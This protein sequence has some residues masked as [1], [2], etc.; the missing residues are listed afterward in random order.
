MLHQLFAQADYSYSYSYSTNSG[1]GG[2]AIPA[3]AWVFILAIIVLV[4]VG[5]WKMFAKAG[6]PGWA[7]IIPIYNVIVLLEIAAKPLWWIVL[8]FIPFVNIVAVIL[9]WIEVGRRFGKGPGFSVVLLWLLSPIGQLILG[10][11]SA[12]YHADPDAVASQGT[13]PSTPYPQASNVSAQPG[14]PRSTAQALPPN[15]TSAAPVDPR[16]QNQPPRNLVQ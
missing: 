4:V 5:M 15:P 2:A 12:T 1:S 8:F 11:G 16:N 7:A 10:F 6:K 3:I 14:D 13:V 9:T